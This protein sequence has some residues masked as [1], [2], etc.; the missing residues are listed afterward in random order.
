MLE[1]AHPSKQCA[2]VRTHLLAIRTQPQMCP[3]GSLCR[4]HCHGH[5]PGRLVLPP[6]IL[7]LMRAAGRRPQS[8]GN[9]ARQSAPQ[10]QREQHLPQEKCAQKGVNSHEITLNT[11]VREAIADRGA[12]SNTEPFLPFLSIK[13]FALRLLILPGSA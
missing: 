7:L 11:A 4:E 6:R 13:G 10:G 12:V 9:R 1:A 8:A 3:L 5:R 2:T